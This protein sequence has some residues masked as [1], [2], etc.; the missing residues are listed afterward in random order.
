MNKRKEISERPAA[1]TQLLGR[2]LSALSHRT[3]RA[4]MLMGLVV[5]LSLVGGATVL[6]PMA[7]AGLPDGRV[8]ELVSPS[9]KS[10]SI[11]GANN[12]E[13]PFYSVA[14]TDGERVLF[15]G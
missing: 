13:E 6:V 15:G 12:V 3:L 8:Y 10:G 7:L 9:E 1:C 2:A 14:S 4:G 5:G 11:A